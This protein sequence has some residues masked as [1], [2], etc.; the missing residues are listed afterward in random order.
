[1][2]GTVNYHDVNVRKSPNGPIKEVVKGGTVV[3]IKETADGWH[4][5][6]RGYIRADLVD[7]IPEEEPKK[8]GKKDGEL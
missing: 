8:K 4:K 2:K 6:D 1:M 5:T 3:T 7:I